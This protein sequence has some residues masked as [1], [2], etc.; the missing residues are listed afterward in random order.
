M[1]R[2]ASKFLKSK[3]TRAGVLLALV[4]AAVATVA[5]SNQHPVCFKL[6]GSWIGKVVGTPV[7]WSYALIPDASGR[8]AALSGSI[9]V[10][11]GP[12][13]LVPGLFTNLEYYSPMVGQVRMT[14]RD[15]IEGTAVW[16]GMKKGFP[17]NQIVCLG[18][19]NV[20][21]KFVEEDTLVLTNHLAFYDPSADADGDGLPDPGA[22]PALC[23]PGK[24]SVETRV[25]I[26]PPCTP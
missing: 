5:W 7:T 26:M 21:G 6:E 2:F 12:S 1:K 13:L 8:S 9:Q 20:Q 17:F 11:L 18:L 10:P 15:R 3:I 16:Y 24:V 22:V 23:V 25:P 14:G 4:A 19:N